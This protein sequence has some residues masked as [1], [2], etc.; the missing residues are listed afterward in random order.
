MTPLTVSILLATLGAASVVVHTFEIASSSP[1][2]VSVKEGKDME[3]WCKADSYWEWCKITHVPSGNS[4]EHAW[5]KTPYN[6]QVPVRKHRTLFWQKEIFWVF[7]ALV[8]FI[9]VR[10]TKPENETTCSLPG[11]QL[12]GLRGPVRVHR[13]RGRDR[14]QVRC[15]RQELAPR[16][17]R[18]VEVR[19][20]AVLRRLQQVEELRGVQVKVFPGKVVILLMSSKTS[21]DSTQD[22]RT[23]LLVN[24]SENLS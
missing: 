10:N 11:T 2:Y 8:R 1:E 7:S 6:V 12:H 21:V 17:F 22:F 13:R 23:H 4:C 14:L 24:E 18:P 15:P 3:L 5:N 19:R 9:L 16:G 20:V